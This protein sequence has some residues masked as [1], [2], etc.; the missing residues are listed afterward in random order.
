MANI[1]LLSTH[2]LR[3]KVVIDFDGES[4]F[5]NYSADEAINPGTVARMKIASLTAGAATPGNATTLAEAKNCFLCVNSE[6][7]AGVAGMAVRG[8]LRGI[9]YGFDLSGMTVGDLIY[10]SDT[11]GRLN[12]VA[13]TIAAPVGMVIAGNVNEGTDKLAFFD[14]TDTWGIESTAAAQSFNDDVTLGA[15]ANLIFV[16]TT[17]QSEVHLTDNLADALSIKIAGGNDFIVFTTTNSAEKMQI[18]TLT[19]LIGGNDLRFTGATGESEIQLTDNL[20]DALSIRISTA[21]NDFIVFDS[22]D[23][24]EKLALAAHA[25]MKLGFFAVTPAVRQSAYTQTYS[26]ADK[27]HA[28]PTQ[29]AVTAVANV[30]GATENYE[31]QDSSATVTQAEWRVMAKTVYLLMG[32]IKADMADTKQVVN[33]IIDDLQAYGLLQ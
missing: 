8:L 27:T 6:G 16:G 10:L 25:S 20:A 18:S 31:F 11:D 24:D 9:V 14:F 33:S 5:P 7:V 23:A 22:T 32:Q 13:G 15:G 17:G 26:T 3:P 29:T 1:S 19:E 4:R 30:T 12:T 28:V 2:L 21:G